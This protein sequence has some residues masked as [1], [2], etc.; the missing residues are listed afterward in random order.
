MSCWPFSRLPASMERRPLE[1]S[2]FCVN[3]CYLFLDIFSV[4]LIFVKAHL[5]GILVLHIQNYFGNSDVLHL[6]LI[7]GFHL[8]LLILFVLIS[9]ILFSF[10]DFF[11]RYGE[12]GWKWVWPL[13][14]ASFGLSLSLSFALSLS[15][16]HTRTHTHIS[17]VRMRWTLLQHLYLLRFGWKSLEHS[18]LPWT[19][20]LNMWRRKS[21]NKSQFNYL[22]I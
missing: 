15:L 1:L 6:S 22:N 20:A 21:K 12:G 4:K 8:V 7:E 9:L 19:G 18:A 5:H 11:W 10:H 13:L 16:S 17:L 14:P 3:F 2:H